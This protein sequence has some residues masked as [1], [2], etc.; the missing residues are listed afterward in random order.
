MIKHTCKLIGA[1]KEMLD[2]NR[3]VRKRSFAKYTVN[4][5]GESSVQEAIQVDNWDHLNDK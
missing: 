3:V 4:T 2:V 1:K 5:L